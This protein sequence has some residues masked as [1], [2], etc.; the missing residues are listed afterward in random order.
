M[1]Q[2]LEF[3]KLTAAT[4]GPGAGR[5]TS[6]RS[7]RSEDLLNSAVKSLDFYDNCDHW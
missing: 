1:R 7:F 6:K 4:S 3:G 5:I 2:I